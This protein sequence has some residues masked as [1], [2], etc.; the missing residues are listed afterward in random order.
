MLSASFFSLSPG[1]N[2]IGRGTYQTESFEPV[3]I[4]NAPTIDNFHIAS[5]VS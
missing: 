4:N 3:I 5:I 1:T 2:S